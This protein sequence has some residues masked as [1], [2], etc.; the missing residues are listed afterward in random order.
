MC[1][2]VTIRLILPMWW[3]ESILQCRIRRIHARYY[4]FTPSTW[5]DKTLKLALPFSTV[6]YMVHSLICWHTIVISIVRHS[7]CP[8]CGLEW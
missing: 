3:A 5:S 7:M 6:A 2:I 8:L 4:T 1:V